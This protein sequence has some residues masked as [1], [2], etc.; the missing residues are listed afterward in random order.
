MGFIALGIIPV[1][2]HNG[3]FAVMKFLFPVRKFKCVGKK[4]GEA[5]GFFGIIPLLRFNS[6]YYMIVPTLCYLC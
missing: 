1:E 2:Q 4:R 3:R 5:A 6:T